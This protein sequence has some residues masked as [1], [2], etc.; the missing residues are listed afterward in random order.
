M[1]QAGTDPSSGPEGRSQYRSHRHAITVSADAIDELGH[2]NNVV[3]LQWVQQAITAYWRA[4]ARKEDVDRLRWIVAS[5]EI[6][7]RKPAYHRDSLIATVQITKHTASRAWFST[8]IGRDGET[9]AEVHSTLCCLDAS[10]GQLV[11]ITPDLAQPF[12][13]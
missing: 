5:H 1:K 9:V 3:Y 10:S 12:C 7:Y 6:F 2:V 4:V 13:L 11:R 8:H